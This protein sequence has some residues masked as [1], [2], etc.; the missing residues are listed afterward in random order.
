VTPSAVCQFCYRPAFSGSCDSW[1]AVDTRLVSGRSVFRISAGKRNFS[2]LPNTQTG[3][4]ALTT[5]CWTGTVFFPLVNRPELVISC[6]PSSD[7]EVKNEGSYTST[8][9]SAFLEWQEMT[10][11]RLRKDRQVSTVGLLDTFH[12][13]N[14][15]QFKS[16][17]SGIF[18]SSELFQLAVW[19][20]NVG[21]NQFRSKMVRLRISV[22][23]FIGVSPCLLVYVRR[24]T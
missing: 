19:F 10:L 18:I 21:G 22:L 1:V 16:G 3:S 7:A 6:S 12:I 14:T 13:W 20:F 11:L 24:S 15:F 17:M 23:G 5:F 8:P 4:R 9:L 2:P